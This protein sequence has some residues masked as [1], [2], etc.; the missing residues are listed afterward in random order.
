MNA[1][2]KSTLKTK[3]SLVAASLLA[4]GAVFAHPG[5]EQ[6]SSFMTGFAHPMGGL[7]H[8]LA[9]VAIGLW[10]AS[11]GGRALWAFRRVCDDVA[12]RRF[13]C[14]RFE[15]PF[16]EQGILLS[17][18]FWGFSVVAKRLPTAFA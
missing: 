7:D 4:S 17:D 8:L 9:M 12:R 3:G 13:S 5:H 6:A 11:M 16:V 10:A 15:V 18:R 14:C 2:K 1:L